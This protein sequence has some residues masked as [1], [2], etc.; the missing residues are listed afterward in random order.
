METSSAVRSYP[1]LLVRWSAPDATI[2]SKPVQPYDQVMRTTVDIPDGLLEEVRGLAS[3][4]HQSVS[5]TVAAV[6]ARGMDQMDR[7]SRVTTSPLTGL[8]NIDLGGG[9][10]YTLDELDDLIDEDA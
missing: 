4:N 1:R 8:P 6:L 7:P 5:A 2:D 10:V 9:K 3:E